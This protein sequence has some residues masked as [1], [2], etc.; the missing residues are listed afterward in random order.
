MTNSVTF[1]KQERLY[2][3]LTK[4]II[5]LSKEAGMKREDIIDMFDITENEIRDLSTNKGRLN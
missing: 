5:K 3:I 1:I 4:V 2:N